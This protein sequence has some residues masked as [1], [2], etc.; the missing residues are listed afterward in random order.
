MAV[1]WASACP[2]VRIRFLDGCVSLTRVARAADEVNDEDDGDETEQTDARD[3]RHDDGGALGLRFGLGVRLRLVFFALLE[4]LLSRKVVRAENRV[5]DHFRVLE[6][7]RRVLREREGGGRAVES[8]GARGVHFQVG[9]G[10]LSEVLSSRVEGA[11]RRR[12]ESPIDQLERRELLIREGEEPDE[13]TPGLALGRMRRHLAVGEEGDLEGVRNLLIVLVVTFADDLGN[14][15]DGEGDGLGR[16][17]GRRDVQ[18]GRDGL[19]GEDRAR[20]I[21]RV[22]GGPLDGAGTR[23]S[24]CEKQHGSELHGRF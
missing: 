12:F 21:V 13:E 15:V 17:I 24:E 16:V 2:R 7:D 14:V 9:G 23:D 19:S 20:L 22:F 8:V 11:A 4:N 5:G 1:V 10:Q 3:D 18:L 6:F